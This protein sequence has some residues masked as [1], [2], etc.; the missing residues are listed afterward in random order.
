MSGSDQ[1]GL[2]MAASGPDVREL[3][4]ALLLEMHRFGRYAPVFDSGSLDE[5]VTRGGA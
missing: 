2:Q 5:I 3:R 1:S 4:S